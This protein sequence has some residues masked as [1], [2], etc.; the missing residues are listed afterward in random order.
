MNNT[1]NIPLWS[2]NYL[3]PKEE[4]LSMIMWYHCHIFHNSAK[5]IILIILESSIP[6]SVILKH[7]G[8]VN[9]WNIPTLA[10]YWRT[11]QSHHTITHE[12]VYH[13]AMCVYLT[14]YI[15]Q[16]T[17]QYSQHITRLFTF[18]LYLTFSVLPFCF[19]LVW[20]F[21]EERF[22]NSLHSTKYSSSS[23][24][25]RLCV[26]GAR[27]KWAEFDGKRCLRAPGTHSIHDGQR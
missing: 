7:E 21:S 1:G 25:S 14:G 13:A 27:L 5:F 24:S 6:I 17:I 22:P 12:L 18:S 8:L 19:G 9:H 20:A 15:T 23:V 3:I 11:K 10:L 16:K 2:F 26:I 4:S